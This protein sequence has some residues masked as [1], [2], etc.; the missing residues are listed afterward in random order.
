VRVPDYFKQ[1]D[2]ASLKDQ[3]KLFIARKF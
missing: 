2:V 3:E 1:M